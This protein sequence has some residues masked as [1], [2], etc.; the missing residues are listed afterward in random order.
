MRAFPAIATGS[1]LGFT[2]ERAPDWTDGYAIL[3]RHPRPA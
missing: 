3:L 1:V 2:A